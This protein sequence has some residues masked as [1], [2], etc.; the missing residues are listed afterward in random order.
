MDVVNLV[1]IILLEIKK[2]F[3]CV[4]RNIRENVNRELYMK[5]K[6]ALQK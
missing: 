2:D 3:K 4:R 5:E 6:E 1:Y